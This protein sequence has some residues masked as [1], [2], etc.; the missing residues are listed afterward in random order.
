MAAL[1]SLQNITMDSNLTLECIQNTE[2][3]AKTRT[4]E[5]LRV[6]HD[7]SRLAAAQLL[8]GSNQLW[9]YPTHKLKNS[10][11]YGTS[12]IISNCVWKGNVL[13]RPLLL[14][15]KTHPSGEHENSCDYEDVNLKF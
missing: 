14:S 15:L 5:L 7:L 3:S 9:E 11:D 4:V 8:M 13:D 6:A 12:K 1:R 2:R 10:F